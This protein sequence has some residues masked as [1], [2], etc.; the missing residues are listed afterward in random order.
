MLATATPDQVSALL[1]TDADVASYRENGWWKSGPIFSESDLEKM[2]TAMYQVYAADFPTGREP[3][4][5]PWIFDPADRYAVRKVDQSHWTNPLLAEVVVNPIVGEIAGRLAGTNEIRLWHDQLLFKPGQ[6]NAAG[7]NTGKVGWHQDYYYW[8]C[9]APCE[10]LTAW[11]AFDD[12][13]MANGCMQVVPGSHKWGLLPGSDFFSQD[14]DSM[15]GK[16][17]AMGHEWKTAPV[18]LKAG[19]VSF[20]HYLTIHGSGPNSTDRPRRSI[21]LHLQ[22]RD[23]VFQPGT[24]CDAHQNA[25]RMMELGRKAGDPFAGDIWHT[26]WKA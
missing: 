9:A 8:Q 19:E 4:G 24:E 23:C 7:A 13:T 22:P 15:K 16:I 1:P 17:E 10:M 6:K 2:R 21:V 18:E 5:G 11:V 25:Q 12:V 14:T 3:H 20:H 26:L